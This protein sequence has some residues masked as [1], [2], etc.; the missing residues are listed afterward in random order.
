MRYLKLFDDFNFKSIQNIKDLSDKLK[1]YK[2]PVDS[3]GKGSAKTIDH[4]WDELESKECV[5][6]EEGGR[7]IRCVEFVGVNIFYKDKSGNIYHLKEDRQEFKD[8]RVRR[9]ETSSMSEKTKPGENPVEAAMRG[10]QEELNVKVTAGQLINKKDF[11]KSEVS[12]SYPGLESKYVGFKFDCFLND[13]QYKENGYIEIQ[14]D[15]STY[16]IWKK[17]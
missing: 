17:K 14:K 4:L 7:L 16:F 8:G 12:N 11:S 10:L 2:I 5:V 15:K 6:K 1:E 9:R 13:D 3:W